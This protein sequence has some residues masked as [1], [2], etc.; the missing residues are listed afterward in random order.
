MDCSVTD[1]SVDV[2]TGTTR[3]NKVFL[4]VQ[5]VIRSTKKQKRWHTKKWQHQAAA[6]IT[7][8]KH[9]IHLSY[10]NHEKPTYLSYLLI[11]YVIYSW[12]KE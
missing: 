2:N 4:K 5:Q 11:Q 9:Y 12:L 6:T 7:K 1:L 3:Y 10:Q 8:L